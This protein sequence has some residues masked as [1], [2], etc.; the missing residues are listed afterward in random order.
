MEETLIIV[1]W[2]LSKYPI[3]LRN[4]KAHYSA[5]NIPL[6]YHILTPHH[7]FLS[8]SL[9]SVYA[10]TCALLFKVA[11]LSVAVSISPFRVCDIRSYCHHSNVIWKSL[12]EGEPH[13]IHRYAD[14]QICV[15]CG[16]L[17]AQKFALYAEVHEKENRG[18]FCGF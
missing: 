14:T 7:I 17:C 16:L 4:V 18:K 8:F 9:I 11:S 6:V 12:L 5:K 1:G 13:E 3:F 10:S 2:L 15:T